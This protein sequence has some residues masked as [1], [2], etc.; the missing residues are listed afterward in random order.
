MPKIDYE[1]QPFRV[2][3]WNKKPRK[4][5]KGEYYCEESKT[6]T[7]EY[8]CRRCFNNELYEICFSCKKESLKTE[9]KNLYYE[10]I[11]KKIWICNGCLI[12]M[13]N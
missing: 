10:K 7:T 3:R 5:K 13:V 4:A 2:C 1:K 12:D 9:M 6:M 11:M 8:N